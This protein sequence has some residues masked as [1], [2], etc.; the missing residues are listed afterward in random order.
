MSEEKIWKFVGV[1]LI[2][3]IICASILCTIIGVAIL[4]T[5]SSLLFGIPVGV[6]FIAIGFSAGIGGTILIKNSI[7][8]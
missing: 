7:M 1:F 4:V 3:G 8:E 6:G 2:V 5:C